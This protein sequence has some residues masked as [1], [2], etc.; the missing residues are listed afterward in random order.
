MVFRNTLK[1]N[2]FTFSSHTHL[3]IIIRFHV[4]LY[5]KAIFCGL[6]VNFPIPTVY[7]IAG[8][9]RSFFPPFLYLMSALNS[10]FVP[11][12]MLVCVCN[13]VCTCVEEKRLAFV[14]HIMPIY[15]HWTENK[16]KRM[17]YINEAHQ[18]I[19]LRFMPKICREMIYIHCGSGFLT[20][21]LPFQM[22]FI[23]A[24]P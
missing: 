16:W 20:R 23:E 17:V 6:P 12:Y 13:C 3:K 15:Y 7:G 19:Y 4:V 8:V 1:Y 10:D 14:A 11:L 21:Q 9:I 18:K 24:V 22:V 5:Q 2:I